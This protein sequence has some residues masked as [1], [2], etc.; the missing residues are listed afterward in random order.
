M[1][2][3]LNVGI[4]QDDGTWK[5]YTIWID[6]KTDQYGNNVAVTKSQTKEQ[7]E[8]KEPKDYCGNGKCFWT[9]GTIKTAERKEESVQQ[10]S[11]LPF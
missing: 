2:A 8:N 1:A 6:D 11:D 5:N 4:K 3:G 7:R 9:D 10:E